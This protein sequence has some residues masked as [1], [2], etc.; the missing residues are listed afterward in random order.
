[1]SLCVVVNVGCTRLF[2]IQIGA[3]GNDTYYSSGNHWADCSGSRSET[4]SDSSLIERPLIE[5]NR[6]TRESAV[7]PGNFILNGLPF[8]RKF[9]F[10]DE[11]TSIKYL[12]RAP[13]NVN[14]NANKIIRTLGQI[15][16]YGFQPRCQQDL[17]EDKENNPI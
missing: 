13:R 17:Y 11:S 3:S 12:K 1:M 8:K 14:L 6:G 4:P 16:R 7:A 5:H 9:G 10:N 15:N 2:L